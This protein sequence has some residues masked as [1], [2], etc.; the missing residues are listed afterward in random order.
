MTETYH[1]QVVG[2]IY[3]GQR[4]AYQYTITAT[5]AAELAKGADASRD[6]G[7]FAQVTDFRVVRETNEYET[8]SGNMWRRIDT[9][10]TMR[11]FR[12]GMTPKRFN[13]LINGFN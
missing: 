2:H 7:D 1:L 13:A 10:Q 11:G 12:A 5:R 9:F 4:C 8:V 3:T 6:A